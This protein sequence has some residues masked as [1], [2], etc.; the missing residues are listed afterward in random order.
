MSNMMILKVKKFP[1]VTFRQ[2]CA[3][4]HPLL[5]RVKVF[6][7][8]LATSKLQSGQSDFDLEQLT[9]FDTFG[10]NCY[11]MF[12]LNQQFLIFSQILVYCHNGF[13][14]FSYISPLY[15][16]LLYSFMYILIY[17]FISILVYT[18]ISIHFYF[19]SASSSVN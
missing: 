1:L 11:H 17:T 9:N 15:S 4:L 3:N 18:L 6:S 8:F 7:G 13:N 14:K 5:N 2:G 12:L 16:C 19:I 10:Q